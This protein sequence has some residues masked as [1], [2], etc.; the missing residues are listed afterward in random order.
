MFRQDYSRLG[1]GGNSSDAS[2]EVNFTAFA[3]KGKKSFEKNSVE[4]FFLRQRGA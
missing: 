1:F 4:V 2:A 3:E